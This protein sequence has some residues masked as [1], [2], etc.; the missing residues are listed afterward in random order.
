MNLENLENLEN[1]VA[2]YKTPAA[3]VDVI[4]SSR[5]ALLVGISGAGKDTLK[6]ALLHRAGFAEIISHT[7][8]L[9]RKNGGIMEQ[10]GVDYYFIN[11]EKA[12]EMLQAGKFIE[13]KFV[14]G[15]VYGTSIEAVQQAAAQGIAITDIDVQG[16]EEYKDISDDV[17]AIFIVPPDYDTWVQRLRRRY[18]SEEAFMQEW[19]T[20]RDSAI[21]ELSRALEVPYYHCIINDNLERAITVTTEI[22]QREDD[23]FNQKDDEAR[24]RARQLLD[25]IIK[26]E[27]QKV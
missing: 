21:H 9:P 3:A 15:T 2:N 13:A 27:G 26:R 7:T 23:V 20:R 10:D 16:V 14:H 22:A 17:I 8:R 6:Q 25:E 11:D 5:I 4:E 1:L 18:V 12:A 24:L 19:P